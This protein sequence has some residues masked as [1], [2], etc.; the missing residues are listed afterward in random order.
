MVVRL[1]VLNTGRL[2]PQEILLVLISVRGWVDPRAIVRSEGLYQWKIPMTPYGIV[3]VTFR[4]V[5]QHLNH[6]ATAVM[7]NCCN[8]NHM[9]YLLVL[10]FWLPANGS[11][12]FRINSYIIRNVSGI[13][14][15][16]SSFYSPLTIC[17]P[18]RRNSKNIQY[19]GRR[20]VT[21]EKSQGN[22]EALHLSG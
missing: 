11:N 17:R 13:C 18:E 20:F 3:P 1:W 14:N 16:L 19:G 9:K 7:F 21:T 12:N 6:C 22:K 10:I 15:W 2:Y 5:A 4:F 8:K